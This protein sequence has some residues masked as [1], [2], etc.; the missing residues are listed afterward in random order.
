MMIDLHEERPQT[1]SFINEEKIIANFT[2]T[3]IVTD[4]N[5]F[6]IKSLL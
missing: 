2:S 1:D 5:D 3:K 4:F 6:S